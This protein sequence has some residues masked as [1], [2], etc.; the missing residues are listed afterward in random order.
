MAKSCPACGAEVDYVD[1]PARVLAGTCRGCG[2]ALTILQEGPAAAEG[3]ESPAPKEASVGMEGEVPG[4]AAKPGRP[5]HPV[6][7]C[8]A[9]GA[10]LTFHSS[11]GGRIE[12]VC[13]DCG[14]TDTYLLATGAERRPRAPLEARG[15]P[16]DMGAPGFPGSRARPCRQCG[17]PLRFTTGAE[18]TVTGEC[19]SCGNRFTLPPRQDRGGGRGGRERPGR[20][21]AGSSSRYRARGTWSGGSGGGKPRRFGPP[22]GRF[23]RREP[24]GEGNGDDG[25][26]RKRRRPRA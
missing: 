10:S 6:P 24:E 5:S 16:A 9:C 21:G 11:S 19:T 13:T 17:A 4:A 14:A 20:Y 1:R 8:R 2:Q 3:P 7:I 18:G 26:A 15:R 22:S 25:T 12:A 23:R